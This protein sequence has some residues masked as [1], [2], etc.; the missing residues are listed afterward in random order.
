MTRKNFPG[1]NS[2]DR[3]V[4]ELLANQEKELAELRKEPK[5]RER[6]QQ[7]S[8]YN[9]EEQLTKQETRRMMVSATAAG[10]VIGMIFIGAMFLFLLFCTNVWFK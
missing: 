1:F 2:K 6:E 10:L 8:L 9:Q 7:E 3:Y 5:E 4:D